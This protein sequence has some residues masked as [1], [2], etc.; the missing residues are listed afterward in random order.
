MLLYG[1]ADTIVIGRA[2][3][4][5]AKHQDPELCLSRLR[6]FFDAESGIDIQTLTLIQ[7]VEVRAYRLMTGEMWVVNG[8]H[9]ADDVRY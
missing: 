6:E 9:S 4:E 2:L 8:S 5:I 7:N 1:R 3:I